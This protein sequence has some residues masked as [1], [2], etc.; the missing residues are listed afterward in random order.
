MYVPPDDVLENAC[1]AVYDGEEEDPKEHTSDRV[2][3]IVDRLNENERN[4]SG[5]VGDMSKEC[6]YHVFPDSDVD[7][8]G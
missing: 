1:T 3:I 8:R 7:E 4:E 2:F 5:G 6:I